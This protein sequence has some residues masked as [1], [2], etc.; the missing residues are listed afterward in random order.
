MIYILQQAPHVAEGVDGAGKRARRQFRSFRLTQSAL[1]HNLR[2][3]VVALLVQK[4][5][6]GA[7]RL[8]MRRLDLISTQIRFLLDCWQRNSI[9]NL[10]RTLKDG[11]GFLR[12]RFHNTASRLIQILH[13]IGC[14]MLEVF[15]LLA[16]ALPAGAD[17]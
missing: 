7:K 11:L 8:D 14:R 9:N 12:I 2:V 13:V 1:V 17:F 3:F 5:C 16:A 4:S 6:I 15:Q 10:Q